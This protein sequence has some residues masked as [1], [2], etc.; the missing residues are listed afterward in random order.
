[1]I[2]TNHVEVIMHMSGWVCVRGCGC[3]WERDRENS[4]HLLNSSSQNNSTSLSQMPIAD[5]AC[6]R[7]L[8]I[9]IVAHTHFLFSSYQRTKVRKLMVMCVCRVWTWTYLHTFSFQVGSGLTVFIPA[10]MNQA[11][12]NMNPYIKSKCFIRSIFEETQ[13]I[14]KVQ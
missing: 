10:E 7:L 14:K 11:N 4:T 2:S 9:D 3:V 12:L 13:P 6:W 5:Y 8:C 1:M